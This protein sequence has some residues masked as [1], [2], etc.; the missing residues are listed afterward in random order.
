MSDHSSDEFLG[1]FVDIQE[2]P[3]IFVGFEM[4]ICFTFLIFILFRRGMILGNLS[5]KLA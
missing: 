2:V 1:C 5:Q 4:T 3:N